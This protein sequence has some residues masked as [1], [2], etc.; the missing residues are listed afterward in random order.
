MSAVVATGQLMGQ[1]ESKAALI[2]LL[3]SVLQP[4]AADLRC[5]SRE[6]L[7]PIDRTDEEVIRAQI[8]A[9][10]ETRQIS[11]LSD[12]QDRKLTESLVGAAMRHQPQRV[13]ARD[14]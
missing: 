10:G 4:L 2:T 3:Q 5:G 14:R 13:A 6:Q 12:Q 1:G 7:I 11:V 8:E 9:F